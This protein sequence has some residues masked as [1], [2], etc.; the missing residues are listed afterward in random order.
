MACLYCPISRLFVYLKMYNKLNRGWFFILYENSAHSGVR[1]SASGYINCRRVH[2]VVVSCYLKSAIF[3]RRKSIFCLVWNIAY[4]YVLSITAIDNNGSL[5]VT[6]VLFLLYQLNCY[7]YQYW[8]AVGQTLRPLLASILFSCRK[9]SSWS[10]SKRRHEVNLR[11][12]IQG[13]STTQWLHHESS[14]PNVP[15]SL[16]RPPLQYTQALCLKN[17]SRISSHNL[18]NNS[19]N[20]WALEIN[21]P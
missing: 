12:C 20:N 21:L 6:N 8:N 5:S 10:C 15:P 1:K 2:S 19:S 3:F 16:P 9:L 18:S 11:C 7:L 13:W 17:S 14:S 4:M